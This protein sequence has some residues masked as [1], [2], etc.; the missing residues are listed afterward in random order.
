[1]KNKKQFF[2]D[3]HKNNT[4]FGRGKWKN[5]RKKRHPTVKPW[6]TKNEEEK[7]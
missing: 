4:K 1:M 3:S 6:R 7:K 2:N 5:F